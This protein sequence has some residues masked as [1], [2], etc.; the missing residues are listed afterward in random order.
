[1]LKDLLYICILLLICK[2]SEAQDFLSIV[3]SCYL[4]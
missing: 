2:K 1:M 4:I 3:V